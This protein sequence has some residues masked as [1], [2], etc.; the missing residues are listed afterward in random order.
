M[1]IFV[2]HIMR[3]L[4]TILLGLIICISCNQK[5]TEKSKINQ[6]QIDK[7]TDINKS[8]N[9]DKR[10]DNVQYIAF[11]G[12]VIDTVFLDSL[13]DKAIIN[14]TLHV[15]NKYYISYSINSIGKSVKG[16]PVNNFKGHF[17]NNIDFNKTDFK[18]GDTINLNQLHTS[19]TSFN[20]GSSCS[21][22]DD[23]IRFE[24][25]KKF[26]DLKIRFYMIL[27]QC[28]EWYEHVLIEKQNSYFEKLFSINSTDDRLTFK[29]IND[30]VIEC[31]Y[32]KA[33]DDGIKNFK[34]EYDLKN[35]REIE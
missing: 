12:R 19:G 34:F 20:L 29:I 23:I 33:F 8:E 3:T 18:L 35:H 17:I 7:K 6:E 22:E 32:D 16:E 15:D 21:N 26:P 11:K 9:T 31:N 2:S 28:S 1:G 10:I 5:K 25:I 4:L 27:P 13:I 24:N 30:S 14:D